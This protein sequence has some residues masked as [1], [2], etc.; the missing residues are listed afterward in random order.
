MVLRGIYP[1]FIFTAVLN[2]VDCAHNSS[3]VVNLGFPVTSMGV[4]HVAFL[5]CDGVNVGLFEVSCNFRT[6]I[7]R[8]N[9]LLENISLSWLH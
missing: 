4:F 7:C 5:V 3:L 1:L 9:T 8:T 6:V 2:I